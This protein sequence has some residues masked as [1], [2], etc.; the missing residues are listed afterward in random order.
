MCEDD[1]GC[2]GSAVRKLFCPVKFSYHTAN[3]PTPPPITLIHRFKPLRPFNS[4]PPTWPPRF[5]PSNSPHS[6]PPH[7][8][9]AIQ[10]GDSQVHKTTYAPIIYTALCIMFGMCA[11]PLLGQVGG[12]WALEFSSFLGPK[13][14]SPIGSMPFHMVQKLSNSRAQPPPTCLSNVYAC[15]QNIMHGAV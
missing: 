5:S 8:G 10:L 1:G 2:I 7:L 3:P 14:H 6:P 15:I 12:G 9:P 4:P 11:Y 13:W